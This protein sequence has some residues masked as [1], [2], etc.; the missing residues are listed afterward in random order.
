[1]NPTEI[2]R[3]IGICESALYAAFAK[4]GEGTLHE[5][6]DRILFEKAKTLLLTTDMPIEQIS[7]QLNFCS[8]TYFRKRFKTHFGITPREMRKNGAGL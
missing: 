2:A 4:L 6:K 5:M 1:M 7:S 3:Q 8:C